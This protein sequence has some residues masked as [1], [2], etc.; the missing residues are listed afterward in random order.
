MWQKKTISVVL[1][2]YNEKRSI[3]SVIRSFE[4]LGI[5]DE[6]IVVNNNA[7]LGTSQEVAKTGA[8]EVFEPRQGYGA[9]IRRGLKE[10]AWDYIIVCE[11]DGTFLARDIYKL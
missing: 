3:R 11:P 5:V 2:T 9:A 6:I 7:A 8:H 1:P 4:R 10:A